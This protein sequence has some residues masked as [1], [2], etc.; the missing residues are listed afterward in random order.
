MQVLA[1]TANQR[2]C[3]T[4]ELPLFHRPL[5]LGILDHVD[6][7]V[8]VI[9]WSK[10]CETESRSFQRYKG[11]VS[12]NAGAGASITTF[13]RNILYP[14]KPD[15]ELVHGPTYF[16]WG[17]CLGMRIPGCR[18]FARLCFGSLASVSTFR[19]LRVL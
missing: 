5:S 3:P 10:L 11:N 2:I 1:H 19:C 9:R 13:E 17:K 14:M 12:Q 8:K 4:I 18:H 6:P 16:G 7:C 15:T